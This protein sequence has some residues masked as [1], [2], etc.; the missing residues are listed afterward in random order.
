MH[1]KLT[2]SNLCYSVNGKDLLKNVSL[3]FSCGGLHA[4]LGPNGSGKS[5]LLKLLTGVWRLS[6]GTV[7]WNGLP[8]LSRKRQE[9]SRVISLVPQNP[10]PSFDFVVEDLVAMGRYPYDSHY[11]HAKEAPLIHEALR[12]VDAWHLKHRKVNQLSFGERQRVYIARALVTESPVLLLDEPTSGLDIRHQLEIW[13]LL[14]QLVLKGKIVAVTTHDLTIA[15]RY[16]DRVLV[17][18]HGQCV[19]SGT[20]A[21]LIT[22]EL[23]QE[24][25]GVTEMWSA[26]TCHRFERL[27]SKG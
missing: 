8:L 25:F 5:S 3:E 2:A 6:S 10:Q 22:E 23:L 17:L 16:C 14:G 7:M 1:Q 9:I 11:W 26:V 15:E 18:D 19:G 20:F 13:S 21:S 24:V 27:K 4:V 12:S